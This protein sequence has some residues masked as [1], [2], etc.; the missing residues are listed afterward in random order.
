MLNDSDKM[1]T[2]AALDAAA[3]RIV[4]SIH[5]ALQ[6]QPALRDAPH[7]RRTVVLSVADKL[8]RR[9]GTIGKVQ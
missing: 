2:A 6:L 4:T 5:E 3:E 9:Q 1:L 8:V 7:A